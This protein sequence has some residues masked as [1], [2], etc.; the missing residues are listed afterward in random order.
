MGT[1]QSKQI[2]PTYSLSNLETSSSFYEPGSNNNF[3][4]DEKHA[5]VFFDTGLLDSHI[6]NID[7]NQST[8]FFNLPQSHI[9]LYR[10]NVKLMNKAE[11]VFHRLSLQLHE[12]SVHQKQFQPINLSY[13]KHLDT[14]YFNL[15]FKSTPSS[16]S[17]QSKKNIFLTKKFLS[18]QRE[19]RTNIVK[20]AELLDEDDELDEKERD[21]EQIY[22]NSSLKKD[23][24]YESF[25]EDDDNDH[26]AIQIDFLSNELEDIEYGDVDLLYFK[27]FRLHLHISNSLL[28]TLIKLEGKSKKHFLNTNLSKYN[29]QLRAHPD[30]DH[31]FYYNPIL[32]RE[33]SSYRQFIDHFQTLLYDKV[34]SLYKK[35]LVSFKKRLYYYQKNLEKKRKILSK[36]KSTATTPTFQER[37]FSKPQLNLN[38]IANTPTYAIDLSSPLNSSPFHTNNG[39]F[40]LSLEN[41][42]SQEQNNSASN[43]L[44]HGSNTIGVSESEML[45]YI[46]QQHHKLV[47]T[48]EKLHRLR[49]SLIFISKFKQQYHHRFQE[50]EREIHNTLN[51]NSRG[52]FKIPS[53]FDSNSPVILGDGTFTNQVECTF[54]HNQRRKSSLSQLKTDVPIS[55]ILSPDIHNDIDKIEN[56]LKPSSFSFRYHVHNILTPNYHA[57]IFQSVLQS[58]LGMNAFFLFLKSVIQE[59]KILKVKHMRKNKLTPMQA[60]KLNQQNYKCLIMALNGYHYE[61]DE[62]FSH[63]KIRMKQDNSKT[64]YFFQMKKV[65]EDIVK[66]KHQIRSHLS[67]IELHREDERWWGRFDQ[68][69]LRI[70]QQ[71][72]QQIH[73][74]LDRQENSN[75]DS[76]K[77]NPLKNF[78]FNNSSAMPP[79]PPSPQLFYEALLRF[80]VDIN[81]QIT[82]IMMLLN[83]VHINSEGSTKMPF[84]HQARI[85][86]LFHFV[87]HLYLYAESLDRFLRYSRS[88]DFHLDRDIDFQPCFRHQI[89]GTPSIFCSCLLHQQKQLQLQ[90]KREIFESESKQRNLFQSNSPDN[91]FNNYAHQCKTTLSPTYPLTPQLIPGDPDVFLKKR[92]DNL[93][94]VSFK[95]IFETCDYEVIYGSHKQHFNLDFDGC[96]CINCSTNLKY[97]DETKP[98]KFN[99]N[100]DLKPPRYIMYLNR[101]RHFY[102]HHYRY[103]HH[104]DVRVSMMMYKKL[105]IKLDY[106]QDSELEPSFTSPTFANIFQNQMSEFFNRSE[107]ETMNQDQ[108]FTSLPSMPEIRPTSTTNLDDEDDI[109]EEGDAHFNHSLFP[110]KLMYEFKLIHRFS[111]LYQQYI[112]EVEKE[113]DKNFQDIELTSYSLCTFALSLLLSLY[114]SISHYVLL[115]FQVEHPLRGDGKADDDEEQDL[116]DIS[117]EDHFSHTQICHHPEP[118]DYNYPKS[119]F[120][121]ALRTPIS[122]SFNSSLSHALTNL[123]NVPSIRFNTIT[124]C[125]ALGTHGQ[126]LDS[127]RDPFL[128]SLNNIININQVLS[129]GYSINSPSSTS[130]SST[131]VLNNSGVS[132]NSSLEKEHMDSTSNIDK[133]KVSP[134]LASPNF[135]SSSGSNPNVKTF[136]IAFLLSTQYHRWVASEVGHGVASSSQDVYEQLLKIIGSSKNLETNDK[137][138]NTMGQTYISNLDNNANPFSQSSDE[139]S[140]GKNNAIFMP[141]I[142]EG[143]TNDNNYLNDSS[144]ILEKQEIELLK[145]QKELQLE[146]Q[147]IAIQL[148]QAEEEQILSQLT[149]QNNE[150]SP[151]I[152][153]IAGNFTDDSLDHTENNQTYF[154]SNPTPPSINNSFFN[155]EEDSSISISLDFNVE[156]F[157]INHTMDDSISDDFASA[158]TKYRPKNY[159]QID[160]RKY[161]DIAL[162][163]SIATEKIA[164]ENSFSEDNIKFLSNISDSSITIKNPSISN[165]QET[166]S[167][168][169]LDLPIVINVPP[170]NLPKK[171]NC[172][173]TSTLIEDVILRLYFDYLGSY[174]SSLNLSLTNSLYFK[175]PSSLP[176]PD[177]I[178]SNPQILNLKDPY[179]DAITKLYN[180][181]KNHN[182]QFMIN[183]IR[184]I[185]KQIIKKPE[186]KNDWVKNVSLCSFD[187]YYNIYNPPNYHGSKGKQVKEIT[188]SED[189]SIIS[190]K[191]SIDNLNLYSPISN[192]ENTFFSDYESKSNSLDSI[193]LFNEHKALSNSD[194][195]ISN[196]PNKKEERNSLVIK[197]KDNDLQSIDILNSYPSDIPSPSS[198]LNS[199]PSNSLNAASR[200]IIN[201]IQK[202]RFEQHRLS[203]LKQR[204]ELTIQHQALLQ[205]HH[206]FIQQQ[207]IFSQKHH[208]HYI[209]NYILKQEIQKQLNSRHIHWLFSSKNSLFLLCKDYS[210]LTFLHLLHNDHHHLLHLQLQQNLI[211]SHQ[212]LLQM[213]V[214]HRLQQ[215][216]LISSQSAAPSLNRSN[217]RFSFKKAISSSEMELPP[218][219]ISKINSSLSKINSS[220]N[221]LK[222]NINQ[223]SGNTPNLPSHYLSISKTL[224]SLQDPP[225]SHH[226]TQS[227]LSSLIVMAESLPLGVILVD[228]RKKY[229]RDDP[230]KIPQKE[231][232][233]LKGIG[234]SYYKN[235]SPTTFQAAV[236]PSQ[237]QKS[238]EDSQESLGFPIIYSNRYCEILFHVHSSDLVGKCC[239][240]FYKNR[241]ISS[242]SGN[243]KIVNNWMSNDDFPNEADLSIPSSIIMQEY[244]NHHLLLILNENNLKESKKIRDDEHREKLKA[245]ASTFEAG[246]RN[247]FVSYSSSS[248][249]SI[250][251]S[252]HSNNSSQI[253]FQ[254]VTTNGTNQFPSETNIICTD[255]PNNNGFISLIK[256]IFSPQKQKDS[257]VGYNHNSSSISVS[258]VPSNSNG[259]STSISLNIPSNSILNVKPLRYHHEDH[260]LYDNLLQFHHLG[261]LSSKDQ[262]ISDPKTNNDEKN[263]FKDDDNSFDPQTNKKLLKK[264]KEISITNLADIGEHFE[265]SSGQNSSNNL[266]SI[267]SSVENDSENDSNFK[268]AYDDLFSGA[269]EDEQLDFLNDLR[270]AENDEHTELVNED[271]LVVEELDL[272]LSDSDNSTSEDEDNHK[273]NFSNSLILSDDEIDVTEYQNNYFSESSKTKNS[274]HSF[275]KQESQVL[276]SSNI[277]SNFNQDPNNFQIEDDDINEYCEIMKHNVT[278]REKFHYL[279]FIHHHQ[280]LSILMLNDIF[281][282]HD[283]SFDPLSSTQHQN[284]FSELKDH[285]DVNIIYLPFFT[286]L[287]NENDINFQKKQSKNEKSA[288]IS[289]WIY[290]QNE[291]QRL[292]LIGY[293]FLFNSKGLRRYLLSFHID[294]SNYCQLFISKMKLKLLVLK[295][296]VMLMMKKKLQLILLKDVKQKLKLKLQKKK[297]NLKTN[298]HKNSP[299]SIHTSNNNNSSTSKSNNPSQK[300]VMIVKETDRAIFIYGDQSTYHDDDDNKDQPPVTNFSQMYSGNLASPKSRYVRNRQLK[301]SKNSASNVFM[302]IIKKKN[303]PLQPNSN[304]WKE[305]KATLAKKVKKMMKKIKDRENT[306]I[307]VTINSFRDDSLNPVEKVPKEDAFSQ[308]KTKSSSSDETNIPIPENFSGN[309]NKSPSSTRKQQTKKEYK[310]IALNST[311]FLSY[312]SQISSHLY[313]SLTQLEKSCFLPSLIKYKMKMMK[314]KMV[315]ILMKKKMLNAAENM[316]SEALK[317]LPSV[318]LLDD[319]D[320]NLAPEVSPEIIKEKHGWNCC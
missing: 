60:Q 208:Y 42:C 36:L 260:Y 51:L 238:D 253:D 180:F 108:T 12:L 106:E 59:K 162:K 110:R 92:K 89:N 3:I 220:I 182:N 6:E 225:F 52:E 134:L 270:L 124:H 213:Q 109:L 104:H 125:L 219:S 239:L 98:F 312:N 271:D 202:K 94:T 130:V 269:G 284:L 77:S 135:S 281:R 306:Q 70:H 49:L 136:H 275:F 177:H 179:D 119:L 154:K 67:A 175:S 277:S 317:A 88:E 307:P 86:K 150:N 144:S 56:L 116:T 147:K 232:Q 297:K 99:E 50:S 259:S 40:S 256:G 283:P 80:Y 266:D 206:D 221:N 286:G 26:S 68:Y 145:Q 84:N 234:S 155:E 280:R 236:P 190:K 216:N 138:S 200:P 255:I 229:V 13:L 193:T 198:Q 122:E 16:N 273:T 151:A 7:K 212:N 156:D 126:S 21:D 174:F 38:H 128:N 222:L 231:S 250:N 251:S 254:P 218:R 131:A 48:K 39:F 10:L 5:D 185:I 276:S 247:R 158:I 171:I 14:E 189:Y 268:F 159:P 114:Q 319:D 20:Y 265:L 192:K 292:H 290:S 267:N 76:D 173:P 194:D 153:N 243:L 100:E 296:K 53:K 160:D 169:R 308:I 19:D 103:L 2:H 172:S 29:L 63:Q 43:L 196:S 97:R 11:S 183:N 9:D 309:Y 61:L 74:H 230:N 244:L 301:T 57:D 237:D 1:T 227:W 71:Y 299:H 133:L 274:T 82:T 264:S 302:M 320:I 278:L 279:D 176:L 166:S 228:M 262:L 87:E 120:H 17:T 226:H 31:Y 34:Y 195:S 69:K 4:G 170:L 272:S 121:S 188:N 45:F 191:S 314:M 293:K 73:L 186:S 72:Y 54:N 199:I 81:E 178:I 152:L 263:I 310:N 249:F 142:I 163:S 107:S 165:I 252:Y 245:Y 30:D 168:S 157:S 105:K 112:S 27:A 242:I 318:V 85:F 285:Q 35:L 209:Y 32:Y 303:K 211:K 204:Q 282:T 305:D 146:Q 41:Y 201:F 113:K 187:N 181:D 217:S 241:L 18:F 15:R 78:K 315:I 75:I 246:N 47:L 311:K 197:T 294:V 148:K 287:N 23:L 300:N 90:K 37:K 66:H 79:P 214:Q 205:T 233:L 139:D 240:N 258:S 91:S 62:L 83:D 55:S 96:G 127:L 141:K 24:D 161:L 207:Y 65:Q 235:K 101:L 64:K 291:N 164:E 33:N 167:V 93:L 58:K 313:E 8:L 118:I 224:N 289:N 261:S 140:L 117:I 102:L 298:I 316:L 203:F 95:H 25:L 257:I 288:N 44:N 215:Q 115:H 304:D 210:M 223:D 46:K 184:G 28:S 143:S 123:I 132:S 149:E 111:F 295:K 248:F 129:S 137:Y 22:P